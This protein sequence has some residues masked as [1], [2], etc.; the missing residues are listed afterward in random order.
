MTRPRLSIIVPIYN[1]E[2]FIVDTLN[3]LLNQKDNHGKKLNRGLYQILIVNNASTDK[4]EEKVREFIKKRGIHNFHILYESEKGIVPARISGVN[5]LFKKNSNLKKTEYLAFCD[6]DIIAPE[7]WVYSI[8]SNFGKTDAEILSYSG[9]FPLEF[10]KKVPKLTKRY[11]EKVGTIFFNRETVNYLRIGGKKFLFTEQ[12]FIDF[13]RPVSGGCYAIR[14]KTYQKVGGYDREFLDKEKKKE[15]DGPT[16]RLVFRL[17]RK[18]VKI[19]YISDIFFESSPRRLLGDPSK[20][21][22][23]KTHKQLNKLEDYREMPK[24]R[25]KLVDN[26]AKK[27]DFNSVRRYVVEYYILLQCVNNLELIDKYGYYFDGIK[28]ELKTKIKSWWRKNMNPRGQ[29]I[30]EFNKELTERYLEKILKMIP[31]QEV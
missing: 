31:K 4:T 22:K 28:D 13:I 17:Q 27:I 25:Y 9:T 26:L 24:E 21:F 12:I 19:R 20:F 14:T 3:S 15:V 10:W 8:I 6:G 7:T 30:F 29:D 16:W 1:E 2:N 11:L 18:R 5:S 23:I